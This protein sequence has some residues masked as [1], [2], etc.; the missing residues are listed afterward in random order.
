VDQNAINT[1][2]SGTVVEIVEQLPALNRAELVAVLKA[3]QAD[4]SPRTTLIDAL[5]KDIA[6]R[7]DE[8]PGREGKD[9]PKAGGKVGNSGAAKAIAPEP[10]FLREDY[11]G[12]LTIDQA[13][14]RNAKF[15]D[16]HVTKPATADRTK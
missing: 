13:G 16:A 7:P 5:E 6:S 11:T 8:E 1:L 12:P 3:E 10:D 14:A 2:R 15:A 4:D 9:K